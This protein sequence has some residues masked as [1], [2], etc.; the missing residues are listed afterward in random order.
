MLSRIRLDSSGMEAVLKSGKTAA[1]VHSAT[2]R[3][4]AALPE[5]RT[6]SGAARID[7]GFGETDRAKG[8]VTVMHA[9][10]VGLEA[11]DGHLARAASAAGLE[12]KAWA[13]S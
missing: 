2:Q 4:A 5:I 11:R 1:A 10:A 8:Y 6:R 13:N 9:V 12:F 3:V 7:V